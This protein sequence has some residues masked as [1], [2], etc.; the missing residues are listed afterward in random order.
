VTSPEE[1]RARVQLC[2]VQALLRRAQAQAK[3]AGVMAVKS[4]ATGDSANNLLAG[5]LVTLLG[6]KS[7]GRAAAQLAAAARH[8]TA[9]CAAEDDIV[10]GPST[11]EAVAATRK[12]LDV[13]ATRLRMAALNY[14][15][16][17]DGVAGHG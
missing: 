9:K 3:R 13:A 11:D 4:K 17:L 2:R 8:Y 5:L 16:A 12:L 7:V 15:A 6:G 1:R 10:L 14:A